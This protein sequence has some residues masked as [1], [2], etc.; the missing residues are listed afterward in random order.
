MDNPCYK[1][2]ERNAEC[3]SICEK[4]KI[5][6]EWSEKRRQQINKARYGILEYAGYIYDHNESLARKKK[7]K[8][9][10]GRK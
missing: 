5:W 3:H 1:C 4:Y 7:V 9:R 8:K 2:E 10:F 6:K